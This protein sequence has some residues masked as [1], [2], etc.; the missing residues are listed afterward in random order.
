MH[1]CIYCLSLQQYLC[2]FQPS[3]I[4][5][6]A[7]GMVRVRRGSE[8]D[9]MAAVAIAGP[10]TIGVDHRHSSFQVTQDSTIH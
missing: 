6:K 4:G 9:L 1:V 3:K 7:T 8:S 10:V 2:F 5:G